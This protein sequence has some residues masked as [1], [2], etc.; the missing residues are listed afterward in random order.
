[1]QRKEGAAAALHRLKKT[2]PEMNRTYKKHSYPRF[3]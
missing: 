2:R 1:M 3:K